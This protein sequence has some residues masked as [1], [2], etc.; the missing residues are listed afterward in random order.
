MKELYESR[1]PQLAVPLEQEST[2]TEF[3]ERPVTVE[4]FAAA[5]VAVEWSP[6]PREIVPLVPYPSLKDVSS[7]CR[8]NEK[9]HVYF[10]RPCVPC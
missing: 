3:P 6:P 2:H 8:L 4:L 7:T 10:S 9:Q 5:T 1:Y